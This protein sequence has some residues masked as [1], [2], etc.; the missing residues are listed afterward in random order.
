M[1]SLPLPLSFSS[2]VKCFCGLSICLSIYLS[3]LMKRKEPPPPPLPLLSSFLFTL[4]FIIQVLSSYSIFSPSFLSPSHSSFIPFPSPTYFLSL[5]FR[6]VTHSCSHFSPPSLPS[7]LPHFHSPLYVS[8]SLTHSFIPLFPSSLYFP[9]THSTT[10][11][12]QSNKLTALPPPP[13][14][15]LS[16][17]LSYHVLLSF[18]PSL[19]PS[20]PLHH[21]APLSPI[22]H[23]LDT[24]SSLFPFLPPSLS[25]LPPS[26]TQP[27]SLS[28]HLFINLHFFN[29]RFRYYIVFLIFLFFSFCSSFSSA[30][31]TCLSV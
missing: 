20:A 8:H 2:S 7:S 9:L 15:S 24:L 5:S 4:I 31:M 30:F 14:L 13:L 23:H 10:Q 27:P 16:H 29:Y 28:S 21:L 1:S 25:F 6:S 3:I 11:M 19:L 22:P 17:P 26:L 12:K 18:S